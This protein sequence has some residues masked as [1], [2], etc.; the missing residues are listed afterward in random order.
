MQQLIRQTGHPVCIN[1]SPELTSTKP[2]GKERR[3]LTLD[4]NP[5]VATE[6]ENKVTQAKG[7]I[8]LHGMPYDPHE[9]FDG[10][11]HLTG[12]YSSYELS[13][14]ILNVTPYVPHAMTATDYYIFAKHVVLLASGINPC[15]LP[16][17]HRNNCFPRSLDD[18]PITQLTIL[19]LNIEITSFTIKKSNQK[20]DPINITY[21]FLTQT[22]QCKGLFHCSL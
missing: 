2:R 10:T 13:N 19:A 16:G 3:V 21:I 15:I 14:V 9:I 18:M 11:L 22:T 1:G 7:S 5:A 8:D 17:R 12:A 6:A 20:G 4:R